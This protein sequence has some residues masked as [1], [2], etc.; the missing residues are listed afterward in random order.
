MRCLQSFNILETKELGF[1]ASKAELHEMC[2]PLQKSLECVD[3]YTIHCMTD[4]QRNHFTHLYS[5]TT[6]V[7][8]DICQE[9][10]Y[11]EEYLVHASCMSAVTDYEMCLTKYQQ[12]LGDK[13]PSVEPSS[14]LDSESHLRTI[15]CSFQDYMYCSTNVVEDHCGKKTAN[16]TKHFLGRMARPLFQGHCDKFSSDCSSAG[17]LVAASTTLFLLVA[18]STATLLA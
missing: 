1:G 9:G 18:T 11:R 13:V 2:N 5:G 17:S 6:A 15:C 7:I 12:A 3:N 4:L 14:D 10:D 16:F 8:R